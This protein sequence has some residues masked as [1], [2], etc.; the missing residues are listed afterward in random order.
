MFAIIV[1]CHKV[2]EFKSFALYDYTGQGITWAKA[3]Q[4]WLGTTW[5]NEMNF[6]LQHAPC[7]GSIAQAVDLQVSYTTVL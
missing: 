5:A 6:G 7:A 3:V 2:V 1:Q 4:G